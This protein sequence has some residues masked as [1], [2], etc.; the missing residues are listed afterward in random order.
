MVGGIVHLPY[1]DKPKNH[2]KP[3]YRYKRNQCE[4]VICLHG[5]AKFCNL[6]NVTNQ[7]F[8]LV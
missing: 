6:P 5:A 7:L 1:M 4:K 8:E 3:I 2:H